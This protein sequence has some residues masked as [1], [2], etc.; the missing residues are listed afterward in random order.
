MTAQFRLLTAALL[1]LT[2]QGVGQAQGSIKVNTNL[3]YLK[4]IDPI[5]DVN[6]SYVRI[7]EVNDQDGDTAFLIRCSER[8]KPN[9]W[10][11][12]RGKN[13]IIPL[14][15][16]GNDIWPA[17]TLRL[18]TDAP[19]EPLDAELFALED[20]TKQIALDGKSLDRIVVGLLAGKKLVMRLS[21]EQF[22]QPLTYTF[23]AQNFATAWNG[24]KACK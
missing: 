13:E 19:F 4:Q 24:V 17:V 12:F 6:T 22:R 23:S 5:T 2:L 8:G 9:V 11:T 1:A 7:F 3:Y 14:D 16:E 20:T 21:G 18:G 10:G 15:A